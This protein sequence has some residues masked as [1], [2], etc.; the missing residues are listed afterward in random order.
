MTNTPNILP[1]KAG[2]SPGSLIHIGDIH[3]QQPLITVTHYNKTHH[4]SYETQSLTEILEKKL[5]DCLTWVNIEG[6]NNIELIGGIGKEFNIHPLVLE[7]ILNTNQRPKF[8]GFEDYQYIVLKNLSLKDSEVIYE[9]VSILL[10]QDYVFTFREKHDDLFSPINQR[11]KKTKSRLRTQ[12]TDYLAYVLLDI[13]VDQNFILQDALDE[14]IDKTEEELLDKPDISTLTKIQKIKRELIFIRRTVSPLRELLA[15]ILRNDNDLISDNTQ[16][17]FKDIYDHVLRIS[18]T[19]ELQ[20]DMVYGLLDMY[21]TQMS[22]HMNEIMKV[23]T[24]FASIF[25][26]LT[27]LAGIYGM[28]FEHM[29]ELKWRYAYPALWVVFIVVSVGLLYFFRKK[30]WL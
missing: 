9:Q 27:F 11:L 6:L 2:M 17:Y 25:I 20:R 16:V 21:R 10:L 22:N 5:N 12:G 24:V 14:I 15:S 13:M 8:E 26:P 4:E 7:D 23:L 28:N 1:E 29:P 19:N 30:K 3:E 18:E